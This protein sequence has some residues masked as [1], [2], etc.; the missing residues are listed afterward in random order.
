MLNGENLKAFPLKFGTKQG[1]QLL[2]LLLNIVL[3]VQA[4]AMRQKKERKGMQT[5]REEVK[6][7][8]YAHDMI[9]YTENPKDLQRNH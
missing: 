6:L 3:Q 4:S 1:C 9:Q 2:P 8:L 5:G 7:S